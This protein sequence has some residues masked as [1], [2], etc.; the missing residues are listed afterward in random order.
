MHFIVSIFC[1]N[2]SINLFL[3]ISP[4][5][6]SGS[7][8]NTDDKSYLLSVSIRE[9]HQIANFPPASNI[10]FLFHSKSGSPLREASGTKSALS[11]NGT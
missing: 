4:P 2:P 9:A 7:K 5:V 11:K 1:L 6:I 3:K 8:S 10:I